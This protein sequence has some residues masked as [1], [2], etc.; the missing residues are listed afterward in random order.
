V[1]GEILGTSLR[2]PAALR[3]RSAS[4]AAYVAALLVLAAVVFYV[5]VRFPG[6]STN[7]RALVA[8]LVH[9]RA[10]KPFV[11]RMLVPGTVRLVTAVVPSAIQA[12]LDAFAADDPLLLKIWD[13]LELQPG[14]VLEHATAFVIVYLTLVGFGLATR[15]WLGL[16]EESRPYAAPLSLA[17]LSLVPAFFRYTSYLYDPATLLLF[18]ASLIAL[19]ERRFRAYCVLFVMTTLNKETSVLLVLLF[20]IHFADRE[21]MPAATWRRLLAFQIGAFAA[22][23]VALLVAYRDNLGGFVE[24]HLLRH[25]RE[26]LQP[27]SLAA[28]LAVLT[29]L[30]IGALGWHRKPAFLRD[31]LWLLVALV[32]SNWTFGWAEE[33]RIYYEGVPIA[34]ALWADG[35]GRLL[36]LSASG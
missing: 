11:Y 29:A 12:R 21:R 4:A 23:K 8:D 32:V 10:H 14:Y 7:D 36:R 3:R 20:A 22:I 5:F 2:L 9:G 6:L 25:N 1:N 31:G 30:L 34:L 35:A 26:L 19:V 28:A 13:K 17:A 27:F 18:T 24:F 16:F 15:R 33:L